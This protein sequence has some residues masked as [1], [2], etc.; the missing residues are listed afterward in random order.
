MNVN[1]LQPSESWP[2][3][4]NLW[5]K[6]QDNAETLQRSGDEVLTGAVVLVPPTNGLMPGVFQVWHERNDGMWIYVD[7]EGVQ[8]EVDNP[9]G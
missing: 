7:A 6:I 2:G 5:S 4:E 1:L 8:H 3:D 9:V